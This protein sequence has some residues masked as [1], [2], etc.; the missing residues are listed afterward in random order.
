[1]NSEQIFGRWGTALTLVAVL[2]AATARADILYVSSNQ[3][4]RIV[5]FNS[6]GVGSTFVGAGG[7]LNGPSGLAID[8]TGNL[9]SAGYA[10]PIMKYNSA[11]AGGV[12]ASTN[13]AF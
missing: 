7:G 3:D 5:K 12:F 13:S 10:N 6:A 4:N 11:G 8:Q 9:Y 2:G 1:M